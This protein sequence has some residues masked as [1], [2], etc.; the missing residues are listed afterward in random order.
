MKKKTF[1]TQF[2][3]RTFIKT[4]MYGKVLYRKQREGNT[5]NIC[6]SQTSVKTLHGFVMCVPF[7]IQTVYHFFLHSQEHNDDYMSLNSRI[8]LHSI[9]VHLQDAK[10]FLPFGIFLLKNSSSPFNLYYRIIYIC[11]HIHPLKAPQYLI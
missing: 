6:I 2:D 3:K 8:S 1:V 4:M 10:D 7:P 11:N 5:K 9:L